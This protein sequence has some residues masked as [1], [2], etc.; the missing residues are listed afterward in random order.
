MLFNQVIKNTFYVIIIILYSYYLTLIKFD[1][2]V[3]PMVEFIIKGDNI[4]NQR[5]Q[6]YCH[7]GTSYRGL[8][9]VDFVY[10]NKS[11]IEKN[12]YKIRAKLP[13][14][15]KVTNI[16]FDPLPGKGTVYLQ[17]F[18]VHSNIWQNINLKEL[19]KQIKPLS[20]IKKI[21]YTND[22]ILMVFN[23][24]DPYLEMTDQLQTN[25]V[26]VA[27][28][29]FF[30]FIKYFIN[31]F[32]FL[33][34]ALFIGYYILNKGPALVQRL[35]FIKNSIDDFIKNR[36]LSIFSFFK[37]KVKVNT[38]IITLSFIL[39]FIA[40]II[41][42]SHLFPQ[43]KIE[44][45]NIFFSLI[46][47]FISPLFLYVLFIAVTF[48]KLFFKVIA[49]FL[50]FLF[51]ISFI[52]DM[53]LFTLNGMHIN[54]GIS[55]LFDGGI[56]NFGKNLAFTKLSWMELYFYLAAIIISFM[57]CWVFALIC[58]VKFKNYNVKI[59]M[60][61]TFLILIIILTSSFLFQKTS[62]NQL[63]PSKIDTLESNHALYLPMVNNK[64]FIL[65]YDISTKPFKRSDNLVNKS[66][67]FKTT[68]PVD[69]IYIFI[70]ES[71][72][73]DIVDSETMPFLNK[74]KQDSWHFSR[75][76]SSGNATHYGWYSIINS[77]NPYYWERY[78]NLK[79]KQ[80]SP[81]LQ[82]FKNLGFDINVYTAKDLSYLQIDK[83]LFGESINLP[84]YISNHP[85]LSPPEHD[86]RVINILIN[87]M[88]NHKKGKNL[89]LIFLDS[90]HYPYRWIK[91]GF[92]E[93][94]PYA[95]TASKGVNL[96]KAKKMTKEDK[97][98]IFNRYRNS[99]K[100]ADM[101][102]GKFIEKFQQSP[103]VEKSL[104]VAVGDHGQ[105]FLEHGYLL[106]GFTLYSEDIHVPLYIQGVNVEP[107]KDMQTATHLDI[108]PTLLELSGIKLDANLFDGVS[109]LNGEQK[110]GVSAAAG[111]QNTPY[112][113]IVE[114]TNYKLTF[115][116]E[117]NNP[118]NSKKL[119]VDEILTQDG[120]PFIP[121]Q[122]E[123]DDYIKFIQ[124][125]FPGFPV[126]LNF[127]DKA[128]IN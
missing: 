114:N 120:L 115:R 37:K 108:M 31:T 47:Y 7:D 24:K 109:L 49:G 95:G 123:K 4:E 63:T 51:S 67:I 36:Y 101:L 18:R 118:I 90:S 16:R 39:Y 30:T 29:Y 75:A 77:N 2:P 89:N 106:H 40:N 53:S 60:S 14:T 117:K 111:M 107:R 11:K 82:T 58:E 1:R 26:P 105:Q 100:F 48:E 10:T 128:Q 121:N 104:V 44:N 87:D 92:D 110:Y 84:N 113:F 33:K 86:E 28:H 124:K 65:E 52:V 73:E 103:L 46:L 80:G 85:D 59:S 78:N 81:I 19:F 15:A 93:I 41:F 70:F 66:V 76:I 32:L 116:I 50:F 64:N 21:E 57:F 56:G 27:N 69:N 9:R 13:C 34:L 42:F 94:N 83:V 43:T 126:K 119:Y 55:M 99:N 91:G 71:L 20:N 112:S 3:V 54:H 98:Q 8:Y 102:F 12:L 122:G 17:S 61:K 88:D 5:G 6:I 74:F 79:N 96:T 72:R 25:L 35:G 62:Y 97:Q 125:E 23:G 127:I 38:V 68:S 22:G 45:L